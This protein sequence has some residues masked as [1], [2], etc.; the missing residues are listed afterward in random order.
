MT[1]FIIALI[2]LIVLVW[3]F[4]PAHSAPRVP[5]ARATWTPAPPT[6]THTPVTPLPTSAPAYP[7]PAHSATPVPARGLQ[8]R[9]C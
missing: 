3:A 9:S 5:S 4:Q 8:C 6:R 1:K 2:I 7:A